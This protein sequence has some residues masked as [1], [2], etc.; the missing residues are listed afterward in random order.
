M[1]VPSIMPYTL[2]DVDLSIPVKPVKFKIVSW[3]RLHSL[4][5]R[6]IHDDVYSK[7]CP[8]TG[9]RFFESK[10]Y[11]KWVD[12]EGDEF[13]NLECLGQRSLLLI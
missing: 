8:G 9:K 12:G 10:E 11:N 5:Y 13:R 2:S 6:R 4:S 7:R 3:L 1:T